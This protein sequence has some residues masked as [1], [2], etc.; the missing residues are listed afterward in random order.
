M[1]CQFPATTVERKDCQGGAFALPASPNSRNSHKENSN[2]LQVYPYK[3]AQIG[4][5]IYKYYQYVRCMYD[6]L[7]LVLRFPPTYF[8]CSSARLTAQLGVTATF[9]NRE[10]CWTSSAQQYRQ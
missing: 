3:Y 4:V 2:I 5:Y 7:T 10:S 1:Y 6:M 9:G 8:V